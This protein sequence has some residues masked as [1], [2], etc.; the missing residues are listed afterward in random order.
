MMNLF[1]KHV[2]AWTGVGLF[3]FDTLLAGDTAQLHIIGF[4]ADGKYLAVFVSVIP[5]G[6]EGPDVRYM[7]VTRTLNWPPAVLRTT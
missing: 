5:P 3:V 2:P 7:V 1:M 4:C 6:F